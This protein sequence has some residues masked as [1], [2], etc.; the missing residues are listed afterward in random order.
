MTSDFLPLFRRHLFSWFE[1]RLAD[2]RTPFRRVE[3]RPPILTPDGAPPDLILWINRD[4]LLAGAVILIP[5]KADPAM[6]QRGAITAAALGLNRFITWEALAVNLWQVTD[7]EV[8]LRK[9]WQL[10]PARQLTATDFAVTGDSLLQEL[11]LSA[12]TG[13]CPPAELPAE[14]FANLCLLNLQAMQPALDEAARMAARSDQGDVMT[15]NQARA[16]GWLTLW[17]LLALLWHR[18]LPT[19]VVPERLEQAIT[20]AIADLPAQQASWLAPTA[21]E[22]PLPGAVAT[23]FQHLAGRLA[24][25]KW[26]DDGERALAT[27]DLLLAEAARCHQL[28]PIAADQDIAE[29]LVNRLPPKTVT[30]QALVAP[31]PCLAGLVLLRTSAGTPL[32]AIL[33]ED[34]A[35][36][37]QGWAPHRVDAWL[38]DPAPPTPGQRRQRL[39]AL[40]RAWPYRRLAPPNATPG[41]VWEALF[42]SGITAPEGELILGLPAG[43]PTLPGAELLWQLLGELWALAGLRVTPDGRQTLHLVAIDRAPAQVTVQMAHATTPSVELPSTEV[44]LAL[45]AGLGVA[46]APAAGNNPRRKRRQGTIEA[47]I[48][49]KVFRDGVPRF[50]EDYLRRRDAMPLCSYRLP[51]PLRQDS[52]FFGFCRLLGP[53]GETLDVDHPVTAEALVLAG[54]SGRR[55]VSLPSE[56]LMTAELLHAYQGDLQQLWEE[57]LRECRRQLSRQQQARVMARHIWQ[58]RQLPSMESD[59]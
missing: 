45:L 53:A 23:R 42:L 54:A 17:R 39:A 52:S 43:W 31:R 5:D 6:L 35:Q 44:P 56:A 18:R 1:A 13:T 59:R 33:V 10:P 21:D 50:P 47:E 34:V 26:A 58:R 14:H 38:T 41:W 11:R 2:G 40:R 36:I 49:A 28:D 48:E 32:P 15:G 4:S 24:Q 55:Q 12:I 8:T 3:E 29:L 22:V 19:G 37:P 46:G 9:G 20:Y 16:K 27:L 51:G 30:G 7:Q 25:L 57:L